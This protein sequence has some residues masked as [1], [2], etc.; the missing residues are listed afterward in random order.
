[1]KRG[2]KTNSENDF[3]EESKDAAKR[4]DVCVDLFLKGACV[5]QNLFGD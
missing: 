2:M 4:V 3:S 5:D 1:M